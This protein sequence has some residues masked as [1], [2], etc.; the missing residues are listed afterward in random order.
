[1]SAALGG[2]GGGGTVGA[3]SHKGNHP[4]HRSRAARRNPLWSTRKSVGFTIAWTYDMCNVIC[5]KKERKKNETKITKMKRNNNLQLFATWRVLHLYITS[6]PSGFPIIGWFTKVT[7][8]NGPQNNIYAAVITR[9]IFTLCTPSR[10][11]R[12]K[13][14]LIRL[15]SSN[16]PVTCKLMQ[17]SLLLFITL[18]NFTYFI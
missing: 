11:I 3:Q 1:M 9:N 17:N 15:C 18:Q 2:S 13:Y 14:S 10:S 4:Q 6:C 12:C 8:N 7:K 5:K 16:A